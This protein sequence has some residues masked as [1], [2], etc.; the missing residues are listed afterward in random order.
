MLN[1]RGQH[2]PAFTSEAWF[3]QGTVRLGGSV[4]LGPLPAWLFVAVP[5]VT[6]QVT[7]RRVR[8]LKMICLRV[9]GGHRPRPDRLR[10]EPAA[11]PAANEPLPRRVPARIWPVSA[12]AEQLSTLGVGPQ[13]RGR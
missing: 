2:P 3:R 5:R 9:R 13:P 11:T 12:T 4:R 1:Q 6:R 10:A 7:G 8:A